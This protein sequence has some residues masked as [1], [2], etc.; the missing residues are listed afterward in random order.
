MKRLQHDECGFATALNAIGGKWK[1]SILWEVTL[2]PRRFGELRRL[3]AGISE[4]VLTQQ[5][6]EMEADG[7]VQRKV[8]HGAVTRVEYSVTEAGASL[9]EAVTV[10]SKWGKAQEARTRLRQNEMIAG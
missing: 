7:L 6:R 2:A 9:N 3:L 1:T 4:K 5:L 8:F 10:L